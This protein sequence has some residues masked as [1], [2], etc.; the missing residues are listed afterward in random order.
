MGVPV[1]EA[2]D[3]LEEIENADE[4]EGEAAEAAEAEA[5]AA[6]T[7]NETTGKGGKEEQ[8]KASRDA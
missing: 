4:R 6:K 1:A 8:D 7:K 2:M 5:E 3:I